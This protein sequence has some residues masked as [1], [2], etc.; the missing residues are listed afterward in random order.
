MKLD[1]EGSEVEVLPDL[2][3]TG[4]LEHVDVIMAEWHTELIKDRKR[5]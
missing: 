2:V 4:A 5:R 3:I 1:I